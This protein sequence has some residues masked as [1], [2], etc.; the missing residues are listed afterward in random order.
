MEF[1]VNAMGKKIYPAEFKVR[2]L[3]ELREGSTAADLSR[4][5]QIPM[6][7][8][9]E[10]ESNS[11]TG[12]LWTI[13]TKIKGLAYLIQDRKE[14]A[15][16]PF[17]VDECCY[18]IGEILFELANEIGELSKPAGSSPGSAEVAVEV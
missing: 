15:G 17:D 9:K 6:K 2:V 11:V 14:D 8:K 18:G 3:E 13:K 1:Q 4:Q 12:E 7:K 16:I 5:Y 10:D